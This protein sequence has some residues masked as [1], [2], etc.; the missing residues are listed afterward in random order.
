MASSASP[1]L[2]DVGRPASCSP[3][4]V[5]SPEAH[6]T[7]RQ[8]RVGCL[9]TRGY[10]AGWGQSGD[11]KQLSSSGPCR[12]QSQLTASTSS[13]AHCPARVGEEVTGRPLQVDPPG[14]LP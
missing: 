2:M 13:P 9:V 5:N 12:A 1:L 6:N 4:G 11:W 10:S 7:Q 8:G 3:A 14:V